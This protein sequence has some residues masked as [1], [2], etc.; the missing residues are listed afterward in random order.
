MGLGHAE[1]WAGRR[2]HATIY[3]AEWDL[4]SKGVEHGAVQSADRQRDEVHLSGGPAVP[5]PVW[6]APERAG[7]RVTCDQR[8]NRQSGSEAALTP[9]RIRWSRSRGDAAPDEQVPARDALLTDRRA[10]RRARQSPSLPPHLRDLGHREPRP[11]VG[12]AVPVPRTTARP[13]PFTRCPCTRAW[14]RRPPSDRDRGD[15]VAAPVDIQV[16]SQADGLPRHAAAR[17]RTR[18]SPYLTLLSSPHERIEVEPD[19]QWPR[20]PM[21]WPRC[22]NRGR[23]LGRF[24]ARTWL[25]LRSDTAR[26]SY[27]HA[28]LEDLVVECERCELHGPLSTFLPP[29]ID[30]PSIRPGSGFLPRSAADDAIERRWVVFEATLHD[31]SGWHG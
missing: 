19:L 1:T 26:P 29:W 6:A 11:Q 8:G 14:G 5:E 28:S 9:T 24:W 15:I 13:L 2:I 10:G 20:A 31:P 16:D 22:G 4:G 18:T 17:F 12:R 21:R 7:A 3:S 27:V 30:P 25:Q 23:G